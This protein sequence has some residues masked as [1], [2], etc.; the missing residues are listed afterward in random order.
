[1]TSLSP[2][3]FSDALSLK[4]AGGFGVLIFTIAT[5]YSSSRT[6]VIIEKNESPGEL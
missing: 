1:M 4:L 2:F 5:M 3:L 6:L